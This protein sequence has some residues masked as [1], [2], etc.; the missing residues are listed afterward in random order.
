MKCAFL[1][2]LLAGCEAAGTNAGALD[3]E[4]A[5]KAGDTMACAY[6]KRHVCVCVWKDAWYT[7]SGL[8]IDPTGTSCQ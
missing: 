7:A 1:I 5:R 3:K 4:A 8:A 2:M 6:N